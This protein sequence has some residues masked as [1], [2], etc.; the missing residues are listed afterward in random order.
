M[1]GRFALTAALL[2][3]ALPAA[4]SAATIQ[5]ESGTRGASISY[6]QPIG[7]TFTA[8]DN[9]LTSIG[10]QFQSLNPSNAND[11]ITLTI[12]QGAGLTGSIL[13]TQ[14][15]TLPNS[16]NSQT[17]VWFDIALANLGVTIGEAYTAVLTTTGSFRNA[18]T[19][20]PNLNIYT[21]EPLTG[22][23]YTGGTL[24]SQTV[25]DPFCTRTGSCDLNFRVS[26]VTVAGVPEPT[27]WAMLIAG[28]GLVGGAMRGRRKRAVLA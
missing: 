15:F 3:A 20:G 17:P 12:R 6:F 9:Q 26:G 21:G 1:F 22:D 7:Q 27:T 5:V 18:V 4:A 2:A 25:V 16:I 19:F 11:A 10:F 8:I 13:A 23:A 14:S 24:V 28:F